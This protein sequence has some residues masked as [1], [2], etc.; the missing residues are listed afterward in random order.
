MLGL[1]KMPALAAAGALA[2]ALSLSAAPA[3]L[4]QLDEPPRPG[5]S[6]AGDPYFPLDGNGGYDVRHYDL[7][8]RYRPSSDQLSGVATIHARATKSLSRFN[9]D[10]VGLRVHDIR[11]NGAPADWS[12]TRHELRVTPKRSL[13]KHRQFTIRVVYAGVPKLTEGQASSP[14]TTVS[15]S[16]ASPTSRPAGSR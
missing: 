11:V 4:A 2:L 1:V 7:D 12:R 3:S 16:P 6:G 9:L 14:P 8:L 13:R 5:A 10:L 15:T